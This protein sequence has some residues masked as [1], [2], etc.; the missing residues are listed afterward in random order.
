MKKIGMKIPYPTVSN[1]RSRF[2]VSRLSRRVQI[3]STIPASIAPSTTSSPNRSANAS[4]TNSST[5]AQRRVTCAVA[6]WPSSM[7][8]RAAVLLASHG[9]SD[10]TMARTPTK[11]TEISA[12]KLPRLPRNTAMIRIGNSSPTAPAA[13]TLRPSLPPSIPLSR[14]IGSSVPSAVV[15]SASPTG[16]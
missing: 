13:N 5:T 15:V 3:R 16:T 14:R 4:S 1:F 12:T 11:M 10:K 6:S 8:R 9:T 2:S 7:M